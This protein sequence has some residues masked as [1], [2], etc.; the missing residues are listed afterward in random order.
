MLTEK[1]Y[2][3]LVWSVIILLVMNLSI[4]GSIIWHINQPVRPFPQQ[5]IHG[6]L[7]EDQQPDHPMMRLR[8]YK[9]LDLSKDQI[10]QFDKIHEQFRAQAHQIAVNLTFLRDEMLNELMKENPDQKY[11]NQLADDIGMA[12]R[13][14]KILTSHFFLDVKRICNKDQTVKLEKF[15]RSVMQADP[16]PGQRRGTGN[17]YRRGKRGP[18]PRWQRDSLNNN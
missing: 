5:D 16:P 4:I 3:I 18:G 9:E 2:K 17:Q 7:P 11:L 6:I 15:F 14:L 12:H 13:D 1:K 8:L 10:T